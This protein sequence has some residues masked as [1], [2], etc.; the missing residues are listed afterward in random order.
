ML[1]LTAPVARRS[2]GF[3]RKVLPGAGVGG[4]LVFHISCSRCSSLRGHRVVLLFKANSRFFQRPGLSRPVRISGVPFLSLVC[5]L[6][7]TSEVGLLKYPRPHI[8]VEAEG[9]QLTKCVCSEKKSDQ[10]T[11]AHVTASRERDS[12]LFVG[13]PP[14]LP[15]LRGGTP[16]PCPER[17]RDPCPDSPAWTH[18]LSERPVKVHEKS[19]LT[20]RVPGEDGRPGAAWSGSAP[21]LGICIRGP[22]SFLETSG[23][24]PASNSPSV[25]KRGALFSCY[26]DHRH[27]C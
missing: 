24:F 8:S 4:K 1:F 14:L 26:H 20:G 22:G 21:S 25:L 11:F 9:G 17:P 12:S 23:K 13:R 2:H 15:A 6:T 7:F 5:Q 19:G 10:G 27:H 3:W 16:C 18:R